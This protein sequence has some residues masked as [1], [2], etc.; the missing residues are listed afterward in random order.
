MFRAQDARPGLRRE[1]NARRCRQGA[2]QESYS[3]SHDFPFMWMAAL[4]RSCNSNPLSTPQSAAAVHLYAFVSYNVFKWLHLLLCLGY[5]HSRVPDANR[6]YPQLP[7][8]LIEVALR[9]QR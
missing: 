7:S 5:P 1:E 2:C 8:E 9:G 3:G 4:K 6:T